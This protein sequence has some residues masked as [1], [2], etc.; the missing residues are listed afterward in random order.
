MGVLW[1]D[2]K[3]LKSAAKIKYCFS[4]L[5]YLKVLIKEQL[6]SVAALLSYFNSI[7]VPLFQ[8]SLFGK[9]NILTETNY[10]QK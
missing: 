1:V 10:L 8:Y 5:S 3:Y 4:I 9:G 2:I 7:Q 6:K